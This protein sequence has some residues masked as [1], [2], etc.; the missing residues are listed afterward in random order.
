MDC[1]IGAA[2]VDSRVLAQYVRPDFPDHGVVRVK[3][4]DRGSSSVGMATP[5]LEGRITVDLG[6]DRCK[7]PDCLVLRLALCIEMGGRLLLLSVE[8]R[9]CFCV[10]LLRLA[11]CIELGG[12]CVGPRD[13]FCAGLAL[14]IEP[15]DSFCIEPYSFCFGLSFSL[16]RCDSLL[17][18]GL[19]GLDLG[20]Q[21]GVRVLIRHG[22]A[23]RGGTVGLAMQEEGVGFGKAEWCVC[24]V[25]VVC[26][27]G[28]CF[29]AADF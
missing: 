19:Q 9:N 7:L 23:G 4:L 21:D 1:N 13:G 28:C 14:N 22:R 10:R 5:C 26:L 15:R 25:V 6:D 17:Q 24:A 18:F 3:G 27:C 11:L 29:A 2:V 16:E 12:R 8:L 20:G